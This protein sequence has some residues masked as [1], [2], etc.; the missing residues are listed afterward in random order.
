MQMMKKLLLTA[1]FC[2][3]A[4]S[5]SAASKIT[6][7]HARAE[8]VLSFASEFYATLNPGFSPVKSEAL[9]TVLAAKRQTAEGASFLEQVRFTVAQGE[10]KVTLGMECAKLSQGPDGKPLVEQVS[11]PGAEKMLLGTLKCVFNEHYSFG[12]VLS[13]EYKDGGYVVDVVEMGSAA[14]EAGMLPGDILTHIDKKPLAQGDEGLYSD[15]ALP[16]CFTGK[17]VEFTL[18]RGGVSKTLKI[19]PFFEPALLRQ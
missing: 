13:N 6:I 9:S 1:L 2:C 8:G 19:A 5:C 4:V 18:L 3:V 14:R 12:Y 7:D 16:A 10:D 11:R 15:K 17:S